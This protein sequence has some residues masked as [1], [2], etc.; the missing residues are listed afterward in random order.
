MQENS[1]AK[2][3]TSFLKFKG[4]ASKLR[5]NETKLTTE[6]ASNWDHLGFEGNSQSECD[7]GNSQSEC[8]ERALF[9]VSLQN[10]DL[11]FNS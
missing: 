6:N 4:I 1:T 10:R 9:W 8:D 3:P 5:V 2:L 11:Y 7:E